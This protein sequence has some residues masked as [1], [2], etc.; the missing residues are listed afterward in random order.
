MKPYPIMKNLL[1]KIEETILENPTAE[2]LAESLFISPVHLQRLFKIAFDTTLADYIRSRRLAASLEKLINSDSAIIDIALE[3]GF[4]HAQSYI[5]AFKREFGLT[6]GEL[7]KTGQIV[8][9]KPPLQLFSSNELAGGLLFGPEIVYVPGFFCVGRQHIIPMDA[10]AETV[11]NAGRKFWLNDKH[12]IPNAKNID[13]YIG[14]TRLCK[15]IPHYTI[16]TPSVCVSDFS[17]VPE[18][19]EGNIMP[20]CLCVKF[21]YVGEHHYLDI[22][23]DIA[24][25]M[26]NAIWRFNDDCDAKYGLF[27]DGV[28]IQFEKISES[29][30]DGRYCKMEWFS[31]VYEKE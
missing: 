25:G 20:S 4:E 18:G 13:T 23:S 29:D 19:F 9:V 28:G 31:P 10:D 22:N 3:Y 15:E 6:P 14:F 24:R 16:Y 21:H 8:K 26:Y 5:R 11:A 7:R 17:D 12:K 30:Y 1:D 2:K 27:R